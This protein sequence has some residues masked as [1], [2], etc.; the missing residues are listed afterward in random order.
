MTGFRSLNFHRLVAIAAVPAFILPVLGC[1]PE[2]HGWASVY[3]PAQEN[4]I[5]VVMPA[6]APSISQ[7]FLFSTNGPKHLGIDV[8][9]TVGDPV[10]AA[11][12]GQVTGSFSE[13]AYGNR[14]E[15]THGPDAEGRVSRTV[16]KHLDKRL[17]SK[18]DIVARGQKIG[19]LGTTGMLGGGIPHLHFEL[20]RQAGAEGLV[21][22]D[23]HRLW[24]DGVGRVTCFDPAVSYDESRF[25]MTYPAP[26]LGQAEAV[27]TA[28]ATGL[29]A[30]LQGPQY[31]ADER[32]AE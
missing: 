32:P 6:G 12:R 26:C 24:V 30:L 27:G 3:R 23:P 21:S 31:T 10:I 7:Q 13:P 20:Y 8:I 15:I 25:R 29:E 18:G 14:V 28:V 19:T 16:Y 11:A 5:R 1:V 4:K 2:D 17:V 22:T 9:G